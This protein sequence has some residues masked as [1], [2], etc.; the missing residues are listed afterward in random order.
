M[1]LLRAGRLRRVRLRLNPLRLK[2]V[3]VERPDATAISR[4]SLSDLTWS[5]FEATLQPR[6][7]RRA[8]SWQAGAWEVYVNVSAGGIRRRRARFV[9]DASSPLRAVDLTVSQDAVVTAIPTPDSGVNVDVRLD[10]A[11]L[12]SARVTGSEVL[13]LA[14]E[15]RPAA[16][17]GA[18]A[19]ARLELR[20]RGDLA[21]RRIALSLTAAGAFRAEA[22]LAELGGDRSAVWDLSVVVDGRRIPVLLGDGAEGVAWRA[23]GREL[24]L[25]RNRRGEAALADREPHP[26]LGEAG[27]T[28]AGELELAGELPGHRSDLDLVLLEEDSAEEHAFPVKRADE[29]F[30][31]RIAPAAVESLAGPLPLAGGTWRILM[32][33]AG[34]PLGAVP[35]RLAPELLART[36]LATVVDHK[37]LRLGATEDGDAV[38]IALRDLDDD[39][40]GAYHQRRLL[41]S[42]Y[43][44]R[45]DAPLREA[46]VYT[47]FRGRQYSDGPR[48]IHEELVRR[49]DPLEHF[50]V[51]RDQAARVPATATAL[52]AGSREHYE[53]MARARYLVANDHFPE[54]FTRRD[55]QVCVQTWHGTPLKRMGLDRAELRRATQ[56]YRSRWRREV[57]NWQYVISPNRFSTPILRRSYEIEG[58]LLELGYPRTDALAGPGREAR[59]QELRRRLGLPGD[60]RV[61]LYAPTYRDHAIDRR[62]RHRLD[63]T[64]DSELLR[65]AIGDESVLLVRPHHRIVDRVPASP[66][67]L[68]RD[69]SSYPDGTELLLAA[70]V[71]VTDYSSMMV[72]FAGTGRPLLLFTYD[73]EA[74]ESQIRGLNVDLAAIAP[75]PLLRTTDEL[76]GALRDLDGVR[77]DFA[78]RYADFA[79]SF[80]ELDDGHAAARVAERIFGPRPR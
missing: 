18:A 40:R 15:I 34:E 64:L 54:W 38:L 16:A 14:G 23:G 46:V 80:C 71:L 12:R 8:G 55:D 42:S 4:Q 61:V 36:P 10:W 20:R 75:G 50:W 67:G 57:A 51:V 37:P 35:L 66:D 22:P 68:I 52:R 78:R 33:P 59:S 41:E 3:K 7:L 76:A 30:S 11:T 65:G 19:K 53:L 77:A 47:S 29:G 13:E 27:W 49:G 32:R 45:R 73:L 63:V 62:G 25:E 43:D 58:E 28:E 56:R 2:T 48:A 5:G 69:M 6:S 39:E 21:R 31:A 70:D 24:A 60:K 79:A 17:A 44:A 9:F 26:L 72:D 1:S 74:Y